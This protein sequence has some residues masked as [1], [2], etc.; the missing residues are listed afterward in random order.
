[1]KSAKRKA[2]TEKKEK[3]EKILKKSKSTAKHK[4]AN[5]NKNANKVSFLASMK[6]KVFWL[7]TASVFIGIV[8]TISI[9][10]PSTGSDS[11]TL[12]QNYMKDMT[13][14]YGHIL[15]QNI[16]ISYL[17]L[18]PDRLEKLLKGVGIEGMDSS[19]FYV[20][21]NDGT[22]LY[23]PTKD[24]IGKPVENDVIG[25][26]AKQV[27]EGN[28]P[29]PGLKDYSFKGSKKSASYYVTTGGSS[30][31]V[32][33]VDKS[34]LTENVRNIFVV[35]VGAGILIILLMG[36]EA[37][38]ISA[39]M[40][41]P[42]L[43]LK[44]IIDR[45]TNMDLRPD[46]QT[47]KISQKKDECG[48]IAKSIISLRTSLA[49][50]ISDIQNQSSLLHSTAAKLTG[51]ATT[52]SSTVQNVEIAITEIATGATN[53]AHET[54]KASDDI[55]LMGTMVENTNTQVS[56]LHHA[57]DAI[58]DSSDIANATL[59]E[60]DAINKKAI[61]SIDVIY[62]QTHTTN[63]SALKIKE[64]TTLISSIADETNLLSLNASIEAARAGEAGR[65]F[66]VVAAQIQKLAEQSND[67]AQQID[68]IIYALLEDSE[69]AV[70][71]ME[72]V[73]T[74]MAQQSENVSKAGTVFSQVETGIIE[75]IKGIGEIAEHTDR[76]N[77]TRTD[78]TDVVQS[79]SAIAEENAASTEETSAAILEVSQVV[80]DITHHAMELQEVAS[81][82]EENISVFQL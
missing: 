58:K 64:A 82:L 20:V 38:F 32:L 50:L 40:T 42:I 24:K 10:I 45:L 25:N 11:L 66:A 31:L 43:Q 81:T 73:K 60:L 63:E 16:E 59:S 22:I 79:L 61:E 6:S 3:K 65:G 70:E 44:G 51:N 67:S 34:E 4:T 52:T 41:R 1:M 27:S 68:D 17:Y 9:I 33:S 76:L 30:I 18:R 21:G 54:Q 71:T 46:S 37:Y 8:L 77:T 80:Q 36:I 19:Y 15:D 49:A 69:K 75:S 23:H 7:V 55:M 53:Q 2:S 13:S 35:A 62:E 28:I 14:A 56:S 39:K 78:I 57:A 48:S 47:V 5:K 12:A 29:K 26:I 74:I 72:E